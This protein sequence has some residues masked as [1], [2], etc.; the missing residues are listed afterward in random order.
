LRLQI[1]PKSSLSKQAW[2]FQKAAKPLSGVIGKLTSE[3]ILRFIEILFDDFITVK[4]I[5]GVGIVDAVLRHRDGR[6]ILCEIKASPL[7][8]FPFLFEEENIK[9]A[10]IS[11]LPA[12]R[13]GE[14]YIAPFSSVYWAEESSFIEENDDRYSC[15]KQSLN[16][17]FDYIIALDDAFMRG[18][19]L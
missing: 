11:N 17:P 19:V 6:I 9:T 13:H 1:C 8:T 2:H 7:T 14:D 15:A 4:S 12:Y 3:I 18:E 16:R 10:L 5:G